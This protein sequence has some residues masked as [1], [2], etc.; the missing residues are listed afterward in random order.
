MDETLE[1]ALSAYCDEPCRI[2]GVLLTMADIQD[3]AVFAGYSPDNKSRAAH[4]RCFDGALA[5]A[6]KVGGLETELEREIRTLDQKEEHMVK[7]EEELRETHAEVERL[8]ATIKKVETV[9]NYLGQPI[10]P[11][12]GRHVNHGWRDYDHAPDCPRQ[13]ALAG[14]ESEAK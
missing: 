7:L 12:C 6:T 3:G 11:W 9:T 1:L 14:K 5:L 2:C 10:C 4:K 13:A 8:R